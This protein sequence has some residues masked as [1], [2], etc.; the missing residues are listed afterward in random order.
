MTT[1][2]GHADHAPLWVRAFGPVARRLLTARVPLG[3]N[4]LLTVRG[5]SSGRSRPLAADRS[6]SS[7]VIGQFRRSQAA[8]MVRSIRRTRSTTGPTSKELWDA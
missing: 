4:R 2:I 3:P 1:H 8:P 5:R 7:L 6:S